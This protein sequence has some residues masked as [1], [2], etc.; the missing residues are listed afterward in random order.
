MAER[1]RSQAALDLESYLEQSLAE[2][3]ISGDP[4]ALIQRTA[5]PVNPDQ[6]GVADVFL[7]SNMAIRPAA[8]VPDLD[9]ILNPS[10]ENSS[11]GANTSA[12]QRR[13]QL[14]KQKQ[15]ESLAAL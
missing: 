11:A 7:Q 1:G 10:T 4:L 13:N 12:A 8:P 14:A 6:K 2:K 15:V 5:N 9:G 3:D